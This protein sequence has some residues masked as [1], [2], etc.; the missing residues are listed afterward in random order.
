MTTA[1]LLV[2]V[3]QMA[4]RQSKLSIAQMI[5]SSNQLTLEGLKFSVVGYCKRKGPKHRFLGAKLDFVH[6]CVSNHH[7][8]TNASFKLQNGD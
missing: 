2:C 5:I 6:K 7:R 3:K 4:E 8:V 1:Q